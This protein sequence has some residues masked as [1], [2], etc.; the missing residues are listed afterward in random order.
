MNSAWPGRWSNETFPYLP[1]IMDLWTNDHVRLIVLKWSTQSGKTEVQ[2]NCMGYTISENPGPMLAVYPTEKVQKKVVST[3]IQ[4]MID[5]CP[6]LRGKKHGNPDKF[7]LDEM[8]FMDCVLLVATSQSSSDLSSSPIEYLIG[9][10]LKD[11]PA[12]TSGGKGADPVKYGMDRQRNFPHTRKTM[13]VS[14]PLTEETQ[15][16]KYFEV[17]QEKIYCWV[18]CPHCGVEQRLMFDQVKWDKP[19][20]I[21]SSDPEYWAIAKRTAYYECPHCAGTINDQHKAEMLRHCRWAREDGGDY[22][23]D[24]ES[25]GAHLSCLYSPVVAFGDAAHEFLECKSSGS[26]ALMNF[27]TGWLAEEWKQVIET[28]QEA[29]VLQA[30]VDLKS[31][32]V[33]QEA[34]ALT[35]FVDCQKYGFWFA[36]RAWAADYTSWL[37]HYGQLATWD[38]VERLFFENQYPVVDG[39]GIMKVWRAAVD[40]GGTKHEDSSASMTEEAELW[41]R[42]NGVGRGARVWATK[43]SS[44][45]LAGKLRIGQAMD[46]TPSGKPLPGGLQIVSLDTGKLKDAFHYRLQLAIDKQSGGAYLH[47]ET[48]DIYV[49]HIVSEEKRRNNRGIEEWVQVRKRNDLFD[50]ECGNL[51]LADP[52][53]PG[54]GVN[55]LARMSLSVAKANEPSSGNGDSWIPRRSSWLNNERR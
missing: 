47:S 15:I 26:S 54:G 27:V 5:A 11:W 28:T 55:L 13:L 24:S 42:A 8:H 39:S 9:D 30:K 36:V 52:E 21:E 20:G 10:E 17:C 40:I 12:Y 14:S 23:R 4:P 35:A 34:V 38:E 25:V 6:V 45:P 32:S 49:S 44:T 19:K 43:G 41:V 18:P 31:Q 29:Q 50:C 1:E 51:A 7:K 33:P 48:D 53:W 46:K 22:A 16:S 2:L 37:I 3:R